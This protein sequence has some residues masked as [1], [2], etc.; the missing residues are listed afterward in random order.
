M[1]HIAAVILQQAMWNSIECR[2]EYDSLQR[3][4]S[5]ARLCIMCQ[6][7]LNISDKSQHELFRYYNSTLSAEAP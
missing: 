1:N 3:A 5:T 7:A 4:Q 2:I 6:T